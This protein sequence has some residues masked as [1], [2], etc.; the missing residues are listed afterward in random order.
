MARGVIMYNRPRI[1]TPPRVSINLPLLL[2][3]SSVCTTKRAMQIAGY[4]HDRPDNPTKPMKND[5][6]IESGFLK[7]ITGRANIL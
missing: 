2:R 6:L 5:W 4:V 3:H 1:G 7:E